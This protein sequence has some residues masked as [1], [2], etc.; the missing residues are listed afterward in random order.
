MKHLW[1]V[2]LTIA[3]VS[4]AQEGTQITIDEVR[5]ELEVSDGRVVASPAKKVVNPAPIELTLKKA[6]YRPGT[7]APVG[8]IYSDSRTF[9]FQIENLQF[10]VEVT[11]STQVVNGVQGAYNVIVVVKHQGQVAPAAVLQV[12]CKTLDSLQEI[13]H[14]SGARS[15][16]FRLSGK[17]EKSARVG[18][19]LN[20][21]K[22]VP[23]QE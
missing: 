4:Q 16:S 17:G 23:Q 3:T 9:K 10:E 12:G 13:T 7:A 1:L 15:Q 21:A 11:A 19:I 22:D 6:K 18:V 14:V 20:V 8:D 2:L 5:L